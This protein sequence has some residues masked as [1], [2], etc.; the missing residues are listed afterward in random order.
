MFEFKMRLIC[1]FYIADCNVFQMQIYMFQCKI[2]FNSHLQ[3][4]LHFEMTKK[5][6]FF[7][8][9]VNNSCLKYVLL[10]QTQPSTYWMWNNSIF[11]STIRMLPQSTKR[12][13]AAMMFSYIINW[14]PFHLWFN[15]AGNFAFYSVSDNCMAFFQQ[16]Y[17]HTI[18]SDALR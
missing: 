10:K 9:K 7:R 8:T 13:C 2:E 6:V 5:Y 16:Q 1:H 14:L 4:K 3:V 11:W 17:M 18:S 15:V 12:I